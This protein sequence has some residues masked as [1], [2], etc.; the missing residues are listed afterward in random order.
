[1]QGEY[2]K[3]GDITAMLCTQELPAGRFL[4]RKLCLYIRL[5]TLAIAPVCLLYLILHPDQGWL[6]PLFAISGMLSVALMILSKY[7]AYLP[8]TRIRAG[9]VAVSFALIG[10][11]LPVLAPLTLLLL[12]KKYRT[13]YRNLTSYLYAYH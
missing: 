7:A 1:M 13:A 4:R 10:I 3:T 6:V 5:Y 8:N 12:A 9:Q 2:P 11:L